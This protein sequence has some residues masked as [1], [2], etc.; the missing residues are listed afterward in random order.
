MQK[1][2]SLR[3]RIVM[4]YEPKV[5]SRCQELKGPE[6]FRIREDKRIGRECKYLNNTCRQCDAAYSK[7]RWDKIKYLEEEKLKNRA[8]ARRYAKDNWDVVRE[9]DQA[10]RQTP[11]ARAVRAK[12]REANLEKIQA[13]EAA[14]K[15]RYHIKNRDQLTDA[16]IINRLMQK[17][18]L[19]KNEIPPALIELKRIQI[20]CER[21]LKSISHEP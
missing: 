8:R 1:G 2:N 3:T 17:S 19:A 20:Q 6:S 10:R 5:C 15:W 12:Y 7:A 13:H 21:T 14:A 18:P 4:K 9:K 11:Q 16:Y